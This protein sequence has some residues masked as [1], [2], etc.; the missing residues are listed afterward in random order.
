MFRRKPKVQL[1]PE[2]LIVGLGNPG[3]EYDGTR[4]NVGF[5]VIK[6]LSSRHKIKCDQR[7]FRAHYGI[8]S[9]D[10][11]PVALVRPMTY[12]NLSG[13]AVQTLLRHFEIKP[14][15]LVVVY[16]DMDLEL[17][18]V[19][20][21]PK[22]GAGSHNGMKSVLS[23]V[24]TNEFARVRIGIGSPGST[25]VDHVLSRFHPDEIPLIRDAIERSAE[26]CELIIAE[27]VDIAMNRINP[28]AEDLQ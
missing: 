26:A 18:R 13:E 8:G 28:T 2:W 23:S 9:I 27:G 10:S 3:G 21:K 12:M 20:V 22:G 14:E 25:G 4:H 7:R 11:T 15:R 17:G 24:G 19:R 6:E 1:E 5:E 16:D